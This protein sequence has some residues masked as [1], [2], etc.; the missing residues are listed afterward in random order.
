M[1]GEIK[2]EKPDWL[3]VRIPDL[4]SC[5]HVR[6]VLRSNDVRSVCDSSHCPNLGQ[7]WSRKTA[8]FMI[9][10]D[11]CSRNC[12][13]CAVSTGAMKQLDQEEPVRL[14]QAV[15]ELGLRYVVITSVC[16]DDLIDMGA[17]SFALSIKE[18]KE[19][20][21]ALVEVLIPDLGGDM[22]RLRIIM[23]ARPDVIGH[24][25]ETVHRL[26]KIVRDRRASYEL[27]LQLLRSI[28]EVDPSQVTK[29]SLML[30][31]GE[32][33]EE[34]CDALTDLR[35]AGVD[36]LTLGQ[37]LRP[38]PAQCAVQRYVPPEEFEHLRGKALAMGFGAVMAGP[39]VRSSYQ[40]KEAYD[41]LRRDPIC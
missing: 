7:C 24:N 31:L 3:R 13:F 6:D 14:A 18:V 28:K 8:T 38:G 26:Q 25:L 39:F 34:I 27:S 40:A 30:G 1:G 19:T 16:R 17:K 29:S 33:R 15:R 10:G 2:G 37:Y 9:M 35:T 21:G 23:D 22:E 5:G 36:I 11:R 32:T 41:S 20:T 4:V 12:R